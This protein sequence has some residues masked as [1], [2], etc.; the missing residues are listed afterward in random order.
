MFG[1]L[2]SVIEWNCLYIAVEPV[3]DCPTEYY[4]FG[5]ILHPIECNSIEWIEFICKQ[6]T[7]EPTNSKESYYYYYHTYK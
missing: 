5:R 6:Q 3:S 4:I 7:N 2:V 1:I